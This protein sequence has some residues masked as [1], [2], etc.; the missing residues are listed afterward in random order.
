MRPNY[1]VVYSISIPEAI[2]GIAVNFSNSENLYE[3]IKKTCDLHRRFFSYKN[4]Y[5]LSC[6]CKLVRTELWTQSSGHLKFSDTL[7]VGRS[8]HNQRSKFSND[9]VPSFDKDGT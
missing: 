4:Y 7:V 6:K 5:L 2:K 9:G 3:F 1:G 8:F